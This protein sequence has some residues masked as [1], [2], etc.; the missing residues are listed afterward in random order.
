MGY[1]ELA[2]WAAAEERWDEV[3][4]ALDSLA[5][6]SP[7]VGTIYRGMIA[8]LPIAPTD[9]REMRDIKDA[10]ERLDAEDVETSRNPGLQYAVHDSAYEII[11]RYLLGLLSASLGEPSAANAYA[12]SLE[13]TESWPEIGSLPQDLAY[14]VRAEVLRRQDRLEEALAMIERQA[15]YAHYSPAYHSG[16]FSRARERFL[17]AELLHALGRDEEARRY[18]ETIDQVSRFDVPYRPAAARRLSEIGAG[19]PR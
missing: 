4:V 12:D 19:P 18:Y 7:G 8:T 10:L 16:V 2:H 11:R 13:A 6:M 14:G 5:E 9:S 1:A 15:R 3:K 17:Q